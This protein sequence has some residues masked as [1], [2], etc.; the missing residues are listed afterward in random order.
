MHITL[1]PESESALRE[2]ASRNGVSPER[3]ATETLAAHLGAYDRWFVNAVESGLADVKA[4]RVL[5]ESGSNQRDEARR[6]RLAH[7]IR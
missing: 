4:G 7:R 3:Y 6:A 5:S 1:G 2:L